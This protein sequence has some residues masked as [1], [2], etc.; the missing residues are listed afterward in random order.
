MRVASS[1]LELLF[2]L[3][4]FLIVGMEL[5]TTGWIPSYAVLNGACTKDEAAYYGTIY[6]ML[7]VV[8]RLGIPRVPT[9]STNKIKFMLVSMVLSSLICLV[10]QLYEMYEQVAMF[11]S[12]GFG[13]TVSAMYPLAL[14]VAGEYGIGFQASQTANMMTA[15][16]LSSG[17]L[18][19]LA[20]VLMR[21]DIRFLIYSFFV[22]SSGKLIIFASIFKTLK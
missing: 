7:V 16:V 11:G 14:V 4:F 22:I 5:T 20:G 13:V 2:V 12:I 10:Y 9:S 18:T 21:K 3:A 19:G 17:L 1:K 6:Y 8:L 15:S